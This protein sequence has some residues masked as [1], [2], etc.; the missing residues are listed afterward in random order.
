MILIIGASGYIG[1]HLFQ[2]F[3][4]EGYDVV[5]TYARNYRQDLIHFDLETSSLADLPQKPDYVL[6]C[7]VA[8]HYLDDSKKYWE[9]AYSLDVV[10]IKKILDYCFANNITPI[11]FSSDNVFDGKKGNYHEDDLRNPLT[12]YGRLKFEVENYLFTSQKHFVILRMGKVFGVV[13][14]D[15]TLITTMVDDLAVQQK[16]IQCATDR[17]I[18]P[19]FINDLFY[20]TMKI[21]DEKIA[22][23]YH[24]TSLSPLTRYDLAK[25]I[26]NFFNLDNTLASQCEFRNLQLLDQRPNLIDLNDQKYCDLTA[27]KKIDLSSYLELIKKNFLH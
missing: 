23:V 12:A 17:L 10:Q 11:Y 13:P 15:G 6:I 5:G 4:E 3:K 16:K 26:I 8:Y 18:S 19:L 7:S 21:I 22:G 2:R 25:A 24:L 1:E 20:F 14:R 9:R 27:Q